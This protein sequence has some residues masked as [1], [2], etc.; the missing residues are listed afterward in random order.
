[1]FQALESRRATAVTTGEAID[2][3][4]PGFQFISSFPVAT[5]PVSCEAGRSRSELF[6][7]TVFFITNSAGDH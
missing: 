5:E 6:H 2:V 1:M 4:M 3:G 7:G